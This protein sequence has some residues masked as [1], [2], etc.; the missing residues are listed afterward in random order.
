M[1]R[2][3][4]TLCAGI[5]L[6]AIAAAVQGQITADITASMPV[7]TGDFADNT[8]AGYGIAG[9]IFLGLPLLPI[10]IGGHVGFEQFAGKDD[11]G[12]GDFTILEIAPSIRYQ[13]GLPLDLVSIWGQ[14]GAGMYRWENDATD[15]A[16]LGVS[17]GFGASTR[18]LPGMNILAMPLYH[19]VY[20]DDDKLTYLSLNVGLKF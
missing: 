9:D 4:K 20:S 10:K 16:D 19:I 2:F 11:T 18:V 6:M 3:I 7:S 12:S 13:L 1:Y 14:L 8:D 17:F 5:C 15:G